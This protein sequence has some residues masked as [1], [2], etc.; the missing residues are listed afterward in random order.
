MALWHT[1][2]VWPTCAV[3]NKPVGRMERYETPNDLTVHYTAY[4]HGE[5][6]ETVLTMHDLIEMTSLEGGL[7]FNQKRLTHA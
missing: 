3:C 5:R 1:P 6:E 4:C 7:A 2:D